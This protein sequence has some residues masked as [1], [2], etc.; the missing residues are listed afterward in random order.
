MLNYGMGNKQYI[1]DGLSVTV[2]VRFGVRVVPWTVIEI[3]D[4]LSFE[5]LFSNIKTGCF[6][7]VV[8][9]TEELRLA[10]VK[11]VYVGLYKESLS[12]VSFT[13]S[14][15]GVC[16]VFGSFLKYEVEVDKETSTCPSTRV[17]S[18]VPDT[19]PNAFVVI[20][21]AQQALQCCNNGLPSKKTERTKKDKLFNDI[22]DFLGKNSIQWVDPATHG[23][24]FVQKLCNVLWYIDGHHATLSERGLAVPQPLQC[25]TGYNTP[26]LSKHR[27]RT[28]ENLCGTELHAGAMP[29]QEYL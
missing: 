14:I 11:G 9:M 19:H 10:V 12:A 16:S 29:L 7:R 6:E 28:Q 13:A 15:F 3:V 4:D 17:P 22:I 18:S 8:K 20:M 25:F 21:Q 2:L 26:E 5:Q 27:K 23:A 1:N 24:A